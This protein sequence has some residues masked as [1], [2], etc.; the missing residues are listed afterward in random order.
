MKKFFKTATS[1]ATD[2]QPNDDFFTS[3]L[4]GS[5]P[6]GPPVEV[7]NLLQSLREEATAM[8]RERRWE[9]AAALEAKARM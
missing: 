1:A 8:A 4:A 7:R 5:D 6:I 9:D 2:L 3:L